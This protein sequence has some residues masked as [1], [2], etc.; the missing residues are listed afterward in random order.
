[1]SQMYVETEYDMDM[2]L[3][4]TI[5]LAKLTNCQLDVGFNNMKMVHIF[6]D[7]LQEQLV[8]NNISPRKKDF[9]LNIMVKT[10]EQA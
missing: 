1:M 8:E 6:L 2:A 9:H 3:A 5:K 10:N 4:E 7:N